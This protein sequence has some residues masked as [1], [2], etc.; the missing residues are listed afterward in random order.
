MNSSDILSKNVLVQRVKKAG[1]AL[2]LTAA[3]TLGG[4][5][6]AAPANAATLGN[7]VEVLST[8]TDGSW[9]AVW[10]GAWGKAWDACRAEYPGTRSVEMMWPYNYQPVSRDFGHTQSEWKCLDTL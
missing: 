3:V 5:A 6:L 9:S 8:S 7:P 4:I 2:A 1:T 10:K